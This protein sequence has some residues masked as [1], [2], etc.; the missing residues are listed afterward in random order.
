LFSYELL[1]WVAWISTLRALLALL[2]TL[3]TF[4]SY[5]P[6]IETRGGAADD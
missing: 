3:T 6:G 1:V 4:I 5:Q 2:K